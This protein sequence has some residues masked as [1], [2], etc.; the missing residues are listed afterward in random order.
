[1]G[2]NTGGNP[3]DVR[4]SALWGSGNRGGEHRSNALWGKG[5]RGFVTTVFALALAVPLMAG[6]D[7]GPGKAYAAGTTHVSDQLKQKAK[8]H[9]NDLVDVIVQ[10]DESVS[11]KDAERA[12]KELRKLG[13]RAAIGR[14]IHVDDQP[15]TALAIMTS[16][17]AVTCWFTVQDSI[18]TSPASV[19]PRRQSMNPY[20]AMPR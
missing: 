1:M 4:K 10:L 6:A 3:G 17:A 13:I 15:F 19:R 11:G 14:T 12:E 16:T 2:R 20:T 8:A 7:S 5:G 9:P 18:F